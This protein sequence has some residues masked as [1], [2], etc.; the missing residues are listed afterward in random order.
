MRIFFIVSIMLLLNF[1]SMRIAAEEFD[2]LVYGGTAGG[3][4][5]AI[6]AAEQG[7][8]V[9]LVEPRKNIGG[10]VSGGLGRTDFGKEYVVGG[11][12]RTYFER[13][14]KHYDQELAWFFEPHVAEQA[15]R[16]WLAEAGVSVLF[17]LRVDS[18]KKEG[19][20]ITGLVFENGKELNAKVFI[21]ASYEGDLLPRANVSYTWGREGRTEYGESLAGRLEYSTKHQ[22]QGVVK[23]VDDDDT[24]LPLVGSRDSGAVGEA[25]KKVQAYNFRLCLSKEPDNQL[26]FPKPEG[27][28][29]AQY[30]LLKR[31]LAAH[32]ET[33]LNKLLNIA[34][35][36]NNKT[37]INNN[38]PISTDYI[39]ESW[40]YPEA[41]YATREAIWEKHKKYTQ[42][43]IYFLANDSS[44]PKHVQDGTNQ[45]GIA[46]DEFVDNDHW[47]HQLYIRE[48]R[49]MVGDYVM[50]QQDV[51]ENRDKD[52]SIGMGS[53]NMDS[54]HVQR[55]VKADGIVENEGDMQVG[56]PPYEIPYRILLPK[57]D[58]CTNLLVPVCMS[59]SHVAYSSLRMEPQ[60]MILGQAAG[61]A[62]ALAQANNIPVQAVDIPE[63][64]K[65]LKEHKAILSLSDTEVPY[66]KL[67]SLEGVAMDT[68]DA[69][70]TGTWTRSTTVG[71]Y[72]GYDYLHEQEDKS[73]I[74]TVRYVPK[75]PGK[76][77]YTLRMSYSANGNRASNTQVTVKAWDGT[78]T[79]SIDQ[80]SYPDVAGPWVDLG[81]YI[82]DSEG[83]YVE[84][85]TEGAD[86]Y[87][88]ADA[89]QWIVAAEIG[90]E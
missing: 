17:D 24:L 65:R 39:G 56:V 26:P 45:W 79:L 64:Q 46:K 6:A 38:G 67:S 87:V 35:M 11:M 33:P 76:N 47:T 60:Y 41:E 80:R 72:V 37:D 2:V 73:A 27:Y 57:Q 61:V 16:D 66:V 85:T 25:D 22:F 20:Q 48:A 9:A 34:E 84:I 83:G 54:H 19:H 88:I 50:T 12:S 13:L 81:S 86:G 63:L 89:L 23:G 29:P 42:G 58:E 90:A 55:F 1:P 18:V 10:M 68:D 14:G 32:P 31:F 43:L 69:E 71:P 70:I 3:A 77:L 62:A 44:V 52:D 30:E 75:L 59:A 51:Q 4:I 74:G 8:N 53:Y 21:D 36:P 78:H 15:F 7:A 28:D 82:F 5:A 49:R 40:A